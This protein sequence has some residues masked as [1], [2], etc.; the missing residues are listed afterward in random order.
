MFRND[1][2]FDDDDD[3]C[4]ECHF[5]HAQLVRNLYEYFNTFVREKFLLQVKNELK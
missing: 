4:D 2:S 5:S 1:I 3:M